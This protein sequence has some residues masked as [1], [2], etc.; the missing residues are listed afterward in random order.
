MSGLL[1]GLGGGGGFVAAVVAVGV[2]LR[3]CNRVDDIYMVCIR[4]RYLPLILR[5]G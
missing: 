5:K 3:R 1:E 2:H 4:P